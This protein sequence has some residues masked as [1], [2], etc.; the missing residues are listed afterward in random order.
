MEAGSSLGWAGL[1]GGCGL[2]A[3]RGVGWGKRVASTVIAGCV[4]FQ[5]GTH[6]QPLKHITSHTSSHIVFAARCH[7][8]SSSC[9]RPQ[10][11]FDLRLLRPV[12]ARAPPP[13]SG[14][15]GSPPRLPG[16]RNAGPQRHQVEVLRAEGAPDADVLAAEGRAARGA[17]DLRTGSGAGGEVAAGETGRP[18]QTSP[19]PCL[20]SVGEPGGGNPHILRKCIFPKKR[21]GIYVICPLPPITVPHCFYLFVPKAVEHFGFSNHPHQFTTGGSLGF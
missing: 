8:G 1:E 19:N 20:F 4:L 17:L 14:C 16:L 3:C 15:L 13:P 21:F 6:S 9:L 10:C 11:P 5:F 2:G 18:L 7:L 12:A